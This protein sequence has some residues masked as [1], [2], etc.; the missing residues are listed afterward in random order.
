MTRLNEV[1]ARSKLSPKIVLKFLEQL[2]NNPYYEE[3]RDD[4]IRY[5][6]DIIFLDYHIEIE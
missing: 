6:Y 3:V 1:S 2:I 4:L 5:K